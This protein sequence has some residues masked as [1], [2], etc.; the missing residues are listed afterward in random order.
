MHEFIAQLVNGISLGGIY[1]LIAL[2]YTMVYGIIGL[3]NFA[4]GDIYTLGSFF[5]LSIFGLLGVSG[6]L[7]GAALALDVT[8]AL[9]GAALLCGIVGVLIERLAYRRLRN[10]PR[11]APL[12]T[13]IGISFILENIMQVW[14]GPSPVPFPAVVPNPN[15]TFAG[16]NIAS[17]QLVVV[18]LAVLVMV[19][20]QLFIHKTRIGA[21]MR[22]TAQD[23]DAAQLMGININRTIAIT[24]FV[25]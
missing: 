8:L 22:A 14:K 5:A 11:L 2:G 16:V 15:L 12:I 3:I 18:G 9:V 23:R 21:A 24:F 1:A 13:A 6:E 17:Q 10:A 19:L 7:H 20:L 4:H 25:G